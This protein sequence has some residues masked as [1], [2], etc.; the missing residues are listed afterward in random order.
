MPEWRIEFTPSAY[1]TFAKL[2]QARRKRL[3]PAIDALRAD[4][5][6]VGAKR[7]IADEELW[8]IRVGAYRIVY[9][10]EDDRLVVVLIKVGHRRDVYRGR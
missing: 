9:S 4:P 1:R 3:S 2:D 7:L 10:I 8:R 5:W 6:H